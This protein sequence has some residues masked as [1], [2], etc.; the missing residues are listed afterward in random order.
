M[1]N[2]K[3]ETEAR[4]RIE[5]WWDSL[6]KLTLDPAAPHLFTKKALQEPDIQTSDQRW[7]KFGKLMMDKIHA[8]AIA[9][10]TLSQENNQ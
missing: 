6:M 3:C 4:D 10:K 1:C 8:Q 7:N 5:N 2:E 9:G